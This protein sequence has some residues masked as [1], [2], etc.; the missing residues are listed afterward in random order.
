MKILSSK[1]YNKECKDSEIFVEF[2]EK[3]LKEFARKSGFIK[4]EYFC[5][6][7]LQAIENANIQTGIIAIGMKHCKSNTINF[8]F[9]D[10]IKIEN[11]NWLKDE[12]SRYIMIYTITLENN[13]KYT[14]EGN[15]NKLKTI[16]K[17]LLL[18]VIK[19]GYLKY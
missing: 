19:D 3:E 15:R 4:E 16:Q 6:T 13:V 7:D 18:D 10:E 5:I 8:E 17:N 9:K 12:N 1:M 2:S 11:G 14:Y